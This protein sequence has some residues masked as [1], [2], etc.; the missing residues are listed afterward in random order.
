MF[1]VVWSEF[2]FPVLPSIG[3]LASGGKGF[4]LYTR[5]G[6]PVLDGFKGKPRGNHL[7]VSPIVETLIDLYNQ[8]LKQD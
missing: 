6:P 2:R 8:P 7:E 1:S 3:L 4:W 5:A